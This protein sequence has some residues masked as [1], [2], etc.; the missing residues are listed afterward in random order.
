[1]NFYPGGSKAI[2]AF[3]NRIAEAGIRDSEGT[4][5]LPILVVDDQVDACNMMA[6]L[7]KALGYEVDV[8]YDGR[9][10]LRMVDQRQYG[11]AILDYEMPGMNGVDLFRRI[12]RARPN[13]AAVFVTGYTTIDV[14]FPAIEAGVLQV[15]PKPADFQQLVPIIEDHL[16][17]VA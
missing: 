6:K 17:A 13:M 5:K 2:H 15:I 10:A 1:V 4:M 11:L 12:R 7:L 14:V 9:T 16:N 3:A 8:A